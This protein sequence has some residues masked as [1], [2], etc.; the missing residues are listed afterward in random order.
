MGQ[1]THRK[2][3]MGKKVAEAKALLESNEVILRGRDFEL[4][5]LFGEMTSLAASG[6]GWWTSK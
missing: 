2:I 4:K 1:Q 6:R 3:R 5:I